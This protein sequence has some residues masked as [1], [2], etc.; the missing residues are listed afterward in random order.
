MH[1]STVE[2][3]PSIP[4]ASAACRTPLRERCW[5][6]RKKAIQYVSRARA[7]ASRASPG[8]TPRRSEALATVRSPS[9]PGWL[10]AD[11]YA[12]RHERTDSPGSLLW[13][14]WSMAW[15]YAVHG[16]S[17][18]T[19]PNRGRTITAPPSS[20]RPLCEI[21]IAVSPPCE[22]GIALG[23]QAPRIEFLGARRPAFREGA[24][25]L[26]GVRIARLGRDLSRCAETLLDDLTVAE[27]VEAL[28]RDQH[29]GE[30]ALAPCPEQGGEVGLPSLRHRGGPEAGPRAQGSIGVPGRDDAFPVPAL[31][32]SCV[33]LAP[34]GLGRGEITSR[35]GLFDL[36]KPGLPC[37][38]GLG[39]DAVVGED[40]LDGR[41]Q[42]HGTERRG[43]RWDEQAEPAARPELL[44]HVLHAQRDKAKAIPSGNMR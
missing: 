36:E 20:K 14:A 7:A 5:R 35:H 2:R 41:R 12:C 13:S 9:Q 32:G 16:P 34:E 39:P 23:R 24:Q 37:E 8:K 10:R 44:H 18:S 4:K 29:A 22:I 21:S 27:L 1:C 25:V 17:V 38:L 15:M 42:Q 19:F 43:D 3:S 6:A 28:G 40:V 30:R 11:E 33:G 26:L 31:Q